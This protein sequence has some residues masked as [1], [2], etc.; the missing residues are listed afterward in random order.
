MRHAPHHGAQNDINVGT[1]CVCVCVYE[2]II[3][4]TSSVHGSKKYYQH[5]S[6]VAIGVGAAQYAH[7]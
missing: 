6:V 7:S 2:C 4:I 5:V 1:V 3:I